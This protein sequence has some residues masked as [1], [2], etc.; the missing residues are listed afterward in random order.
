MGGVC[1]YGNVIF[2]NV[3]FEKIQYFVGNVLYVLNFCLK[4][5]DSHILALRPSKKQ[6]R[7]L[8][9]HCQLVYEYQFV[10][11]FNK[12]INVNLVYL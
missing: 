11:N 3:I 2:R 12:F 1:L 5:F 8:V 6:L 4:I 7:Q 10:S 9:Y